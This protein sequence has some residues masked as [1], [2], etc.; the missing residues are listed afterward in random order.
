[1]GKWRLAVVGAI[2]VGLL[3][4]VQ[5]VAAQQLPRPNAWVDGEVYTGLVTPA[6]FDPANGNFDELFTGGNG[7]LD[8][9]PL[10]SDSAPGDTDYNGGRWHVNALK[11]S[12]DPDKYLSADS[13]A[14]LDLSDFVSTDVYFECP[15]L[16]RR[17]G[18]PS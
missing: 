14:D 11:D 3:T 4:S 9:V 8:G 16:P 2:L 12:V 13:I 1:M 15:L 10:I 17:G 7:F 5:V 18:G 6:A